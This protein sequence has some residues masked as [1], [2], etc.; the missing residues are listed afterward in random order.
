M[1]TYLLMSISAIIGFLACAV[2]TVGRNSE[3]DDEITYQKKIS[4]S[5]ND[6]LEAKLDGKA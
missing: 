2:L 3:L 5:L 6:Q 4:K 1:V